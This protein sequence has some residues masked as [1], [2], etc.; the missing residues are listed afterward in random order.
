M[1]IT[2]VTF[3]GYA[4]EYEKPLH[5]GTMTYNKSSVLL[6]RV[7]T[8]EDIEGVGVF[9][10]PV[11]DGGARLMRE[12]VAVLAARINECDP[13]AHE[14]VLDLCQNVKLFGRRGIMTHAASMIDIAIWDIRARSFGIPL[15]TLIGGARDS[16]PVY[17]SGGYYDGPDT[18]PLVEEMQKFVD[19]GARAVKMK[20]GRLPIAK[21]AERIR[22]VR[23]G[24]GEDIL[25][26]L[27]ANGAYNHHE[28]LSLCRRVEQYDPYLFEEPVPA[29]DY[30]GYRALSENTSIAIAGGENEA[31]HH[32]FRDL[33]RLGHPAVIN[34]DASVAGGITEFLRI[35]SIASAWGVTVIPHGL[36]SLHVPLS[37]GLPD[38]RM[39]EMRSNDPLRNRAFGDDPTVHDGLVYPSKTPGLALEPDWNGLE[40]FRIA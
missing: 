30:D 5:N 29:D 34:P 14:R 36:P 8:D 13:L 35:H 27:D 16:V 22:V 28:A 7:R 33:I 31:T 24:I 37:V 40:E 25:L 23:E 1:K 2:E 19:D 10:N 18:G 9:A 15:S 12:A 4:L 39:V 38:V 26:L 6:V 3:R 17:F 11:S 21:D 20:I 32:G